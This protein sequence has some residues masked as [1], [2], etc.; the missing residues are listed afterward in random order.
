M[1]CIAIRFDAPQ[2]PSMLFN[3]LRCPAMPCYFS[4]FRKFCLTQLQNTATISFELIVR[5]GSA[6][7]VLQAIV[8][9]ID[10]EAE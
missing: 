9:K 4:F 10:S 7:K 5:E 8:S 2:C 1:N 6:K 3:A